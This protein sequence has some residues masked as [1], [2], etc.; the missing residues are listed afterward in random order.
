MSLGKWFINSLPMIGVGLL[1]VV[2]FLIWT[3]QRPDGFQTMSA[4]TAG[5]EAADVTKEMCSVL[6]GIK[7]SL[8]EKVTATSGSSPD[9]A[10]MFEAALQSVNDQIKSQNC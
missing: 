5:S 3:R 1:V 8:Q 6:Q 9:T 10:K 7:T 4:G 2:I